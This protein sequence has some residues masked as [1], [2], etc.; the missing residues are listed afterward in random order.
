MK[1]GISRSI[2]RSNKDK[3]F[4]TIEPASAQIIILLIWISKLSQTNP[5]NG[6]S[7]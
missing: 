1:E 3:R 6:N 7:P 4:E 5:K 2:Y